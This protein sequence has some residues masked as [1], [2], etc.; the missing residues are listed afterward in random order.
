[1]DDC[2]RELSVEQLLE[3][4]ALL[5]TQNRANEERIAALSAL[6]DLA[7]SLS[8]ELNLD[9]LL[10]TVLRSAVQV[11]DATAG[12][13]LLLDP[14]T[15]EL[16]F[17]VIEGGGGEALEKRRIRRDQGI[18]GWVATHREPVMVEDATQD[19]RF[20]P[21]IDRFSS[22]KTHS[23]LCVPLMLKGELIGVLQ[24]LNKRSGCPFEKPDLDIMTIFASQSAAAIQNARL[25]EK[26]REERD[27]IMMV[28]ED[29]R[30]R[31]ARDLHDSLAQLLAAS[32]MNV[33]FMREQVSRQHVLPESDLTT[34]ERVMSGAL[35]QVRTMLF[36]LRP[37]ILETDGLVP[38]LE[39]YATRLRQEGT[40][41]LHV[42]VDSNVGRLSPKIETTAY[43]IVCEALNN[44]RRHARAAN[45]WLKV[46]RDSD[47]L[48]VTVED[49]GRG[50]DVTAVEASYGERGSIGL[51]SMRER[52]ETMGGRWSIES[53]LG[54]GTRVRLSVPLYPQREALSANRTETA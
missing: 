15:D 36:D 50:F 48:L 2:N 10:Q 35:Y 24:V 5:R 6:Q 17:A 44:V 51:L 39:T 16:A 13:L 45:V 26:V 14:S 11:V 33:R 30:R 22:F 21:G 23:L 37:V 4:N 8:S 49:D 34:L 46:S 53:T 27:R 47:C 3:V 19:E 12:S 42:S 40:G 43:S 41:K 7:N 54:Q 20:Y 52:A 29:V 32:L 9:P 1:M 28:E 25:Y 38:A 31:L 18:A